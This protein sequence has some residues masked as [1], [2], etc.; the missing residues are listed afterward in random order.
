QVDSGLFHV[1]TLRLNVAGLGQVHAEATEYTVAQRNDVEIL[2]LEEY[3]TGD[4]AV[5]KVDHH[6]QIHLLLTVQHLRYPLTPN[7]LATVLF[8]VG[9]NE[10]RVI[11]EVAFEVRPEYTF[12]DDRR[13]HGWVS[14]RPASTAM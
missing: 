9:T 11:G 5:R 2:L 1:N 12:D 6:H 14:S 7:D 4:F 8:Q 3:P 10:L 13:F